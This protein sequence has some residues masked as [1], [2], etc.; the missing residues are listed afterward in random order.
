MGVSGK[1]ILVTGGAGFIGSQIVE[2]LVHS[3]ASVTVYDNLSTGSLDN[4]AA[5][6]KEIA[7]IEG[8]ILD[9]PRLK[10]ALKGCDVVSHQ[11]A[12]L[13]ITKAI[14]D[15]IQDLTTN[16]I[17]TINVL[18]ACVEIGASRVILA[19]SAGVYGQAETVPQEEDTHPTNPN[20]A[21]GVSKL[22]TEKYGAIFGDLYGLAITSLRYAIVYGP[23]EWYGR[24]LT[25]FLKRALERSPLVVFGDGKQDRDFVF[26]DD[27]V[28]HHMRCLEMD[29]AVGHVFNVSSG[30]GTNIST[31]ADLV[32]EVAGVP[33]L[34]IIHE[35]VAEGESSQYYDRRR[36]PQELRTMVLS[37]RKSKKLLSWRP[38]VE[39]REGLELE[40]E[41]LHA[42]R[43]RW[44]QFSY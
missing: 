1:R 11:A 27:L 22:A 28:V 16:T 39:L 15:P 18:K 23:R 13:E 43:R 7:I 37:C 4:L 24:V 19:S 42:H 9:Y 6:E 29:A 5:I 31:L 41:W 25:I 14:S 10:S 36:L 35:D 2:H 12:Q 20:W 26:I 21:Y 38:Q 32:R 33:E 8:D 17:G 40:Y 34:P 44:Q 30:L 3:G